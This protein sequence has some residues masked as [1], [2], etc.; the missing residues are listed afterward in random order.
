MLVNLSA[1]CFAFG[2]RDSLFLHTYI[3]GF[4]FEDILPCLEYRVYG[5]NGVVVFVVVCYIGCTTHDVSAVSQ[6]LA[7]QYFYS[8]VYGVTACGFHQVL[9]CEA[10]TDSD[11]TLVLS[12]I[13]IRTS[14]SAGLLLECLLIL[15]YFLLYM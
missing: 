10:T 12:I 6:S 5:F 8:G 1:F 13:P 9:L 11:L 14:Q 4:I 7:L 3:H 15:E 2:E